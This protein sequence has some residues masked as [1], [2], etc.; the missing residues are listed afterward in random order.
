MVGGDE[1][2]SAGTCPFA[3][4]AECGNAR[5]LMSEV[6]ILHEQGGT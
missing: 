6:A 2:L 5:L 4:L 1:I 3:P